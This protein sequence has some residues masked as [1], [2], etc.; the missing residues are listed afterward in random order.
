M[1]GA[2]KVLSEEILA[3]LAK[4][5]GWRAVL[6]HVEQQSALIRKQEEELAE[7]RELVGEVSN[8]AWGV[9]NLDALNH[10]EPLLSR[11]DAFLTRTTDKGDGNG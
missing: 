6:D 11:I 10:G 4:H 5:G 2:E 9:N 1:S 3:F 8:N 7:A